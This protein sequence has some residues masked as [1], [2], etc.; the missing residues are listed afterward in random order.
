MSEWA[1]GRKDEGR[2]ALSTLVTRLAALRSFASPMSALWPLVAALLGR[3]FRAADASARPWA[4]RASPAAEPRFIRITRRALAAFALLT[5]VSAAMMA[6]LLLPDRESE[7][8]APLRLTSAEAE[9]EPRPPEPA[10]ALATA[11]AMEWQPVRR[12]VQIY[13]LEAPELEGTELSYQVLARGR[14]ARRDILHWSAKAGREGQRASVLIAIDRFEGSQPPQRPLF[15]DMAQRAA[16]HHASLERFSEPADLR[17]KFGLMQVAEAL[18]IQDGRKQGCSFFRR[19]DTT[20]LVI[21]GWFCPPPARPLDRVALACFLNRI[22]LVSAGP[23]QELKRQ[24]AEAE[25]QRTPCI[26]SRQPG[27]RITWLDHEAPLPAL[28]L[29]A[30]GR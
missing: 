14:G 11:E 29:S 10:F 8:S 27:R 9:S 20:G 28:K 15:A 4:H 17:T 1:E 12:P 6:A 24:F 16:D 21:A 26:T 5:L 19:L 18:L 25:R 3:F 2:R 30:N 23:D 13:A 7:A 22:D